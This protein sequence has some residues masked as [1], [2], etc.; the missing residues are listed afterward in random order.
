MWSGVGGENGITSELYNEISNRSDAIC[1]RSC[2]GRTLL[3]DGPCAHSYDNVAAL[4]L[5][6]GRE[7]GIK[8]EKGIEGVGEVNTQF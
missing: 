4:W 2:A 6:E 7:R 3:V 1:A 5:K 8:I